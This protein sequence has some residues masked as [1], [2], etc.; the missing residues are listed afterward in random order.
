MP[1]GKKRNHSIKKPD[2]AYHLMSPA[3]KMMYVRSFRG[4]KPA[5]PGPKP[6]AK[7]KPAAAK[8]VPGFSTVYKF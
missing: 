5:K 3:E 7:S 4:K 2:R 8:M 1:A 6:S